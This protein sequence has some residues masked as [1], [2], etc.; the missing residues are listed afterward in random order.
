M[1]KKKDR[2]N[3]SEGLEIVLVKDGSEIKKI[4]SKGNTWQKSG[5]ERIRDWLIGLSNYPPQYIT[6]VCDSSTSETFTTGYQE[7]SGTTY[8][9]ARWEVTFSAVGALTNIVGFQ[10]SR[11]AVVYSTVGVDTFT[12]PDNVEMIIKWYT[13]IQVA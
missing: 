6:C 11:G 5:L 13:T 9:V 3:V 10:L 8:A 2:I 4:Q 12:K 1:L 7:A